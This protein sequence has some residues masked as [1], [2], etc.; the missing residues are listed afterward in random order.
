M[1][2]KNAKISKG[3][4]TWWTKQNPKTQNKSKELCND[5][6]K[7][8]P[9]RKPGVKTDDRYGKLLLLHAQHPSWSPIS[10][11]SHT[12]PAS[13]ISYTS[14]LKMQSNQFWIYVSIG[15]I[16]SKWKQAIYWRVHH[17]R[18]MIVTKGA[19]GLISN[20]FP[21]LFQPYCGKTVRYIYV[22]PSVFPL[23]HKIQSM[24]MSYIMHHKYLIYA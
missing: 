3:S 10:P 19:C 24:I 12:I 15:T 1:T 14:V 11:P 20:H 8:F 23:I 17:Q 22:L 6:T 7:L 4:E 9:R 5:Q 13:P 2:M 21:P 16:C 18:S